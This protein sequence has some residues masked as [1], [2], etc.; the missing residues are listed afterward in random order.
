MRV[1]DEKVIEVLT[2]LVI[3][4]KQKVNTLLNFRLNMIELKENFKNAKLSNKCPFCQD[5]K[6]N[7]EHFLRC[8]A[9]GDEIKLE[10]VIQN[11]DIEK[12]K[13]CANL[14]SIRINKRENLIH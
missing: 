7:T 4:D 9:Y 6:D 11:D 1:D 13:H 3:L 12:L 10:D 8:E 2:N 14:I 5:E